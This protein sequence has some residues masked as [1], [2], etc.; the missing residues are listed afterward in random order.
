MGS[1]WHWLLALGEVWPDL[2]FSLPS[3]RWEMRGG[4]EGLSSLG[5]PGGCS[6][7]VSVWCLLCRMGLPRALWAA[8]LCCHLSSAVLLMPMAAT[9]GSHCPV[10]PVALG[11]CVLWELWSSAPPRACCGTPRAALGQHQRWAEPCRGVCGVSRA[12][13]R[14]P[15]SL[16]GQPLC[17]GVMGP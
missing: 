3:A 14:P 1:S 9:L 5:L 16:S 13:L 17:P 11:L 10:W 4:A 8:C 15:S 12:G 2:C 6:I 7:S